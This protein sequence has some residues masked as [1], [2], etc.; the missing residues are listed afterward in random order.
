[1]LSPIKVKE[2]GKRRADARSKQR[3]M[4]K[5][6]KKLFHGFWSFSW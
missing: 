6:D 5:I 2:T 1:M 4:E 3:G